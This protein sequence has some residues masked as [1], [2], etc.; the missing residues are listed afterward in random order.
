[1]YYITLNIIVKLIIEIIIEIIIE[2]T[3]DFIKLAV[4]LMS[5]PYCNQDR[6]VVPFIILSFLIRVT[7]FYFI[8]LLQ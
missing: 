1:M 4:S 3:F 8:S 5:A 7:L 2:L 6:V